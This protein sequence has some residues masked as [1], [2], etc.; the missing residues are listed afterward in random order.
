SCGRTRLLLRG[1]GRACTMPRKN[2]RRS[3]WMC[4]DVDRRRLE[5]VKAKVALSAV[6]ILVLGLGLGFAVGR[7]TSPRLSVPPHA[8]SSSGDEQS[9]VRV[10]TVEQP[11]P[12]LGALSLSPGGFGL[13][14]G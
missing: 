4:L 12:S 6:A 3:R 13:G 11:A 7:T 9:A 14:D 10:T 5:R 1:V 8:A 2:S